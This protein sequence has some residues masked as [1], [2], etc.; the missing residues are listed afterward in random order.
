MKGS[1]LALLGDGPGQSIT[2]TVSWET[3]AL[4]CQGSEQLRGFWPCEV[5]A[6][7]YRQLNSVKEQLGKGAGGKWFTGL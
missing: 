6:L 7:N 3:S 4:Q 2:S 5:M 1:C